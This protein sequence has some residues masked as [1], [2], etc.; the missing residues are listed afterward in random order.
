MMAADN[1]P[2]IRERAYQ[3]WEQEGRPIGRHVDHWLR[4]EQELVAKNAVEFEFRQMMRAFRSGIISETTVERV[5]TDLE[6]RALSMTRVFTQTG[7]LLD[8]VEF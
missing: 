5:M 1:L 6:Q 2:R 4:A 7:G 8:R 3:I